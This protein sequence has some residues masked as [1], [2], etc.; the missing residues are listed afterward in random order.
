MK[1]TSA[2]WNFEREVKQL[3]NNKDMRGLANS[4]SAEYLGNDSA[5]KNIDNKK[6]GRVM[7]ELRP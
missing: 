4:I 1:K 5:R 6:Q 7:N 3:V 2:N